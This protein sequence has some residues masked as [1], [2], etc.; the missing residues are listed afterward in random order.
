MEGLKMKSNIK[1]FSIVLFLS[2]FMMLVSCGKQEAEWKG[3]IEEVDGVTVV[4][5][6]KEPMYEKDVFSLEEELSIGEAEG[7]EEYMFSEIRHLAVDDD[8]R[9]FI[10]DRKES[11]IKVF[12]KNGKYLNKFGR[13][14]QGPGELDGPTMI[15]IN[16][17]ELMVHEIARR[18]SFFSLEGEFLRNVSTKETWALQAK[19]DSMGNVVVTE[20]VM[21]PENPRYQ[22]KKFDAGMNLLREIV[23]FPGPNFR[24]G[25]NPFMPVAYWL[26]D[27][28][29]NIV[30][31]YP[32]NYELQI[33]NP[34]GK[35]IKKITKNYDPVEITD[36]EKEEETRDAPP[37]FKFV[38]SKYHSA[39]RRLFLDD[40]GRIFV[41]TWEK[42]GDEEI[43][44]HDV[45]DSEGKYICEI[46]LKT[47]PFVLKKSKLYT[48]EEDEEGF[49]FVK[50]YKVTWKY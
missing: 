24:K 45:F 21:D 33:F 5:N 7:R 43:Y 44:Y 41:Q 4:K 32:E 31:G 49:Q 10:L 47:R 17:K 19:V 38:F 48:V 42:I 36:E 22:V 39:F 12:D 29:D 16:P 1:V 26:I 50:R 34:E 8:E 46:H 6:P 40:E 23:S 2:F 37:Q 11:H 20:G 25:L 9:I 28:N 3:T 15:S 13:K 14:G 35:L 30:Y 27:E 18:L